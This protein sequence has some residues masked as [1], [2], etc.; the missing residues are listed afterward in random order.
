MIH[1]IEQFGDLIDQDQA[2]GQ[3]EHNAPANPVQRGSLQN[4]LED[5]QIYHH[6]LQR[7]AD[8]KRR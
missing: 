8:H 1:R 4:Q 2:C 5:R 3:T 7:N 6:D